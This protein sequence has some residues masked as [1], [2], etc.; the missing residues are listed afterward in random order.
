M[1]NKLSIT[2]FAL[3]DNLVVNFNQGLNV[4]SGETG[5]GKSVII[6]AFN[7]VLGAK[8]EKNLIRTG[9]SETTVKAEFDISNNL[10]AKYILRDLDLEEDDLLII[11]RK[12]NI[13][14]KSKITIN[15]NNVTLTML[16]SLTATLVDVHGQSEH[17]YL[18]KKSNQLELL[19]KFCF[20][21]GK[22][23]KEKLKEVYGKYKNLLGEIDKLGG[24]E[25]SRLM[26]LD[27][28]DYQINEIEKAELVEGEEEDLKTKKFQLL[29]QEKIAFAL[30][31]LKSAIAEEGGVND[32]LSNTVK[33]LSQISSFSEEY[34][35]L[36][37]K[38]SSLIDLSDE[39][40]GTCENLIDNFDELEV[41]PN[42]IEERLD[43][44]K[45]LK[46]KYGDTVENIYAYL[47]SAKEEKERLEN[48][49]VLYEKYL[50]EKLT[51][52]QN[53]YNL[54]VKLSTLR[55][56]TAKDFSKK[57]LNELSDLGMEKSK[58]EITFN[59]EI[60][61]EDCFFNSANGFDDVEFMFSANLG[62]PVK[63]LSSI[64]SGGEVSRFMLAIKAQTAL[65]NDISTFVFDEID[66]GISG[67]IAKVVA[68][69]FA[70]IA[71][72][73][74]IIAISHL[75]QISA[76]A[77]KNLLIYKV[78]D[79]KKTHTVLKELSKEDKILEITRLVGGET[80]SEFAIQHAIDMI[81]KAN[82]YKNG[83]K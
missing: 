1:L 10:S 2:N 76:M 62:E 53:L 3:I 47:E 43:L 12:F 19:D 77:D 23:L 17:F 58:F 50:A 4:L 75:P 16:K 33:P 22:A 44:I 25:S 41:D 40:K 51:L 39:V 31:T 27:V 42:Y 63:P 80:N 20:D 45:S 8:A 71:L 49:N 38:L 65:F 61:F 11:S 21:E 74:Q 7:F 6:E 9:E 54:Y 28:L 82:E 26:R 15:G 66:A 32:I 78:E 70:K 46:K 64:I 57:V 60:A 29:N 59:D 35:N 34:A 67:K 30:N 5:S 36:L 72:S 37:D 56:K 68:E 14:G 79:G 73:T 52:E 18:L 83:L 81:E 13:D 69:K 24:D 55:K 48:F